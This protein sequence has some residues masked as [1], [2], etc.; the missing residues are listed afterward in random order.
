MSFLR[1][2][3]AIVVAILFINVAYIALRVVLNVAFGF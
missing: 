1:L 3:A 2:V